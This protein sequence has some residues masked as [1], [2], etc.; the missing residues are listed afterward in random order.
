MRSYESLVIFV[1][2]SEETEQ[3]GIITK[4]EE[5]IAKNDGVLESTDKWGKRRLA[6]EIDK[7]REGY[8]ILFNFKA[9]K[10]IVTELDEI[11]RFTPVVLR[12]M[13][14]LSIPKKERKT[15]KK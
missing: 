12:A 4:V 2:T 6:Y 15:K 14:T 11:F 1:P 10:A 8:Y 5:T 3:D 9:D 7:H 13:T